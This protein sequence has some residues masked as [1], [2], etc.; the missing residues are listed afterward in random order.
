MFCKTIFMI[1]FPYYAFIKKVK[2]QTSKKLG[3]NI[4]QSFLKYKFFY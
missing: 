1:G 3:S 2:G 4:K